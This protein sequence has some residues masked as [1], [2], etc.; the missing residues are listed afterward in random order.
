MKLFIQILIIIAILSVSA[1]FFKIFLCNSVVILAFF[2][3]FAQICNF[4]LKIS[5]L[6]AEKILMELKKGD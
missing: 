1:M 2:G 3:G 6:L 4:L 5:G